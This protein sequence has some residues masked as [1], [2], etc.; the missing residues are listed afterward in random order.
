MSERPPP[1]E[2]FVRIARVQVVHALPIALLSL[3]V[4]LALLPLVRRLE[5][6]SDWT[7]LLPR[8]APSVRDLRAGQRRVGGLSTLTVMLESRD[9]AALRRYAAALGP[10]LE[11]LPPSLRVRRAQWN[12]GDYQQFVRDHRHLYAP[13]DE[14]TRARDELRRRV[15]YD[16]ASAMPGYINLDDPPESAE[17]LASRARAQMARVDAAA[18]RF[19]GGYFVHR[20]G[21][22]LAMFL[23]V[24]VQG[25]DPVVARA[26]IARVRAESTA[27]QPPR[28]APDL[29]V[30][31]AGDLP[32][33]LAEHDAIARELVIAT[34]LTVALC[35]V[36]ILGLFRRPRSVVLLGA[37]L[38]VPVVATFALAR[39]TVGH[40][41]TSTAFLG[42]I[43]IGN[44][45]NP[46]IVWLARYF[47]ERRAGRP[48]VDAIAATHE[49][50]WAGTFTA[51][52]AAS[53][54]Y[55]SLAIT[56]FRGFRDFGIIGGA[57]MVICWAL[58]LL[59]LPSL[60]SLWERWRP[61][62]LASPRP[63]PYGVL[64]ARAARRHPA[65]LAWASGALGAAGVALAAVAIARD[66]IDYNFRNL[67][68]VR[69]ETER[70]SALNGVAGE[71]V[72]RAG[73][74]S[75]IAALVERREDTAALRAALEDLRDRHR[76]PIGP[77]RTLDDLLP[78]DQAAKLAVLAD[79]RRWMLDAREHAPPDVR[80]DLDAWLP[81]ADLRALGD[82]DLPTSVAS[83]YTERDGARGRLLFVEEGAGASIWDGRFLVAWSEAVR[84]ARAPEGRRPMVL[85][86][87]TVFADMIEAMWR[88]G[89]RAVLA[90]FLATVGL[91]LVAFR[92]WRYRA[93]TLLALLTGIAWMAGAMTVL[94]LRLNFLNFV[95]L[96]I[97]FGIGVD[98][99]VNV[100]RRY[101]QEVEA[102]A[103]DPIGP[104]VQETGGAIMVCSLTTIFG[105]SALL[106]SA[107]RALQSFGLAAV[108][109]E[110]ACVLAALLGL[111]AVLV[112]V[113]RRRVRS[114]RPGPAEGHPRQHAEDPE[115]VVGVEGYA[116][117]EAQH[118][119]APR[120]AGP[121][122]A[123]AHVQVA[124][125]RAQV[126]EGAPAA[127]AHDQ[128]LEGRSDGE[129]EG[130]GRPPAGD[131]R[132]G[133]RRE[134]AAEVG[135]LVGQ[136]ELLRAGLDADADRPAVSPPEAHPEPGPEAVG[137]EP[138][139]VVA[140]AQVD[141]LGEP[142][143]ELHGEH[144]EGD[145]GHRP[146]LGLHQQH[147]RGHQ[148]GAHR[149]RDRLRR[150]HGGEREEQRERADQG[151]DSWLS[152][153]TTAKRPPT[154]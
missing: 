141:P 59:I 10:R 117:V 74:G 87:A 150:V 142:P 16:R 84:R 126:G 52:L 143:D 73:S 120:P 14:L 54:A 33:G 65:A 98:Y 127:L 40:L 75:A 121:L 89:P 88:D 49:G 51:S 93:L 66:P 3:L 122:Q 44:G 46:G 1:A 149:S 108:I 137:H 83:L 13:L 60:A 128:P 15:E 80:R 139:A 32:V 116:E 135:V 7:E 19:P 154:S 6:R 50:A 153:S 18:E 45:I 23:R 4:T 114:A 25:G 77:V 91:V 63:N 36:A 39:L 70:A 101:A 111:S 134:V 22:H 145:E 136:H 38:F 79:L 115:G 72:G 43:V 133:L 20:D 95:A 138:D 30:S 129:G 125:V 27:L 140:E 71:I 106:T 26:L 102:G 78:R 144:R 123:R 62:P 48:V 8:G 41:N 131:E 9:T 55:G 53:L 5:L 29:T 92:R 112:L 69:P 24:D 104:A 47:E 90:S 132:D 107:N 61:L 31:F 97:T 105:Y 35:V 82:A 12:V 85:G 67:A 103:D 152:A 56:D 113:E 34:L 58:T 96:P 81:P 130:R 42:S 86:N 99:A 109:G 17:A 146:E 118:H 147:A 37:S 57:G 148:R 76:A 68:S 94:G 151:G 21:R 124:E 64:F 28:F 100:M 119:G 11:R 2:R 110:V